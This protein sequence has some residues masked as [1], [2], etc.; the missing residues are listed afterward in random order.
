MEGWVGMTLEAIGNITYMGPDDPVGDYYY[1]KT[2][3][4][5]FIRFGIDSV[6]WGG[7]MHEGI[8]QIPVDQRDCA[9]KR[10]R[11]TIEMLED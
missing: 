5:K 1:I 4:N 8:P 3:D 10:C 9:G 7:N 6:E 2:D 11:I